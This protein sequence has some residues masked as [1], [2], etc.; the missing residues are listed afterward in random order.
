MTLADLITQPVS[1]EGTKDLALVFSSE[2]AAQL[3]AVQSEHGNPR[4]VAAPADLKDGRKMLCADLLTEIGPG[5]LYAQGF[6]HLPA[7]L[8]P[9]VEIL[10]MSA[11]LPLLIQPEEEI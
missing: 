1:Y 3:A 8:F 6:A 10:P 2:L 7:E 5:G 4:H 11:V 9:L